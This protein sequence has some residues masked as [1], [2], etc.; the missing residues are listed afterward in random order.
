VYVKL[1]PAWTAITIASTKLT[2]SATMHSPSMPVTHQ[3]Y[4]K[5]TDIPLGA[6]ARSSARPRTTSGMTGRVQR[7]EAGRVECR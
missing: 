3:G 4:T 2:G 1:W 7:P 6:D 5:I